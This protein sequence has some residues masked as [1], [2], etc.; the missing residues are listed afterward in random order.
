MLPL[1][2]LAKSFFKLQASHLKRGT[3]KSERTEK[4][5]KKKKGD[6]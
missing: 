3:V 1:K 6:K 5:V 4:Q 2:P